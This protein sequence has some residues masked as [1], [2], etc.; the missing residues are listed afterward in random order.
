M[1]V[2]EKDPPRRARRKFTA[3]FKRDAVALVIDE[4]RTVVDVAGSLGIGEGTLGNWVR[5]ARIDAGERAGVTTSER[6]ELA[7]L[8]RENSRLRMERDL[9]KRATAFWVKE[10]GQ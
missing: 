2:K 10:S 4:D 7:N 3:E 1:S 8:R 9:L 5:Q 6:E